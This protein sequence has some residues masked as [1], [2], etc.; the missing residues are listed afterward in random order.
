[1]DYDPNTP[2]ARSLG[3]V[4]GI[5]EDPDRDLWDIVHADML[6]QRRLYPMAGRKKRPACPLR[7][8]G[9]TQRADCPPEVS[10]ALERFNALWRNSG[11]TGG[12]DDGK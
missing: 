5:P 1:M 9:S 10:R 7:A 2:R 4:Y 6:E 12:N 8:P 11:L 3:E